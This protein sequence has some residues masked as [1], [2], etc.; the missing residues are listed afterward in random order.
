MR[1]KKKDLLRRIALLESRL[2][3]CLPEDNRVD[4]THKVKP[5]C[6]GCS[7][8]IIIKSQYTINGEDVVGCDLAVTC[9]D[10]TRRQPT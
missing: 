5:Q 6:F 10:F 9:N 7:H 4:E 8:A 2:D 3:E 1:I